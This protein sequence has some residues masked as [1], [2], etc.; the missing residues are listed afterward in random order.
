MKNTFILFVRNFIVQIMKM[1]HIKLSEEVEAYKK[2]LA[3]MNEM[4]MMTIKSKS[5]MIWRNCNFIFYVVETALS[6]FYTLFIPLLIVNEHLELHEDLK[7]KYIEGAREQKELY[8]KVLELR[9]KHVPDCEFFITET[10]M[11]LNNLEW[12]TNYST[13][14]KHKGLLS[15]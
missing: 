2:C 15:V 7:A 11:N 4:G 3:D 13:Y 14:R 9:G 6:Q 5:K 12:F 8:N 1:E 10:K